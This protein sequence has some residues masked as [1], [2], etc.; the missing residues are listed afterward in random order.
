MI[1]AAIAGTWTSTLPAPR[2]VGGH[3]VAHAAR[4]WHTV[5]VPYRP[6]GTVLP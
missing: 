5:T 1:G 6:H 2:V 3:P 4:V